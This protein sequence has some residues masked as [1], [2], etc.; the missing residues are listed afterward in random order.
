MD[1]FGFSNRIDDSDFGSDDDD[2]SG[3][4]SSGVD[5]ILDNVEDTMRSVGIDFNFN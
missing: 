4:S 3:S 1:Q 2:H 5:G